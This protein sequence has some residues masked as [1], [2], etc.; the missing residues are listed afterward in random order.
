MLEVELSE[1][2]LYLFVEEL[3]VDEH[4]WEEAEADDNIVCDCDSSALFK[5][6]E[7]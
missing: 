3:K 7:Q 5:V 1:E 2:S 4:G 6:I